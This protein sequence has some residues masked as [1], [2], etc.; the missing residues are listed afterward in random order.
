MS[1]PESLASRAGRAF[2]WM[3]VA[4]PLVED[5]RGRGVSEELARILAWPLVIRVLREQLIGDVRR[6]E[7]EGDRERA[8]RLCSEV[9][10]VARLEAGES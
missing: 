1:A 7:A 9:W 2:A 5:F 6:A 10:Q 4:I 3:A 8:L